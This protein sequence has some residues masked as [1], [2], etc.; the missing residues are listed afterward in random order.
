MRFILWG[1]LV[2]VSLP[3][4]GNSDVGTV[5]FI[6]AQIYTLWIIKCILLFSF[7]FFQGLLSDIVVAGSLRVNFM[8]HD[9]RWN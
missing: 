3:S 8:L 7:F 1:W 2:T 5:I 4:N 9:A 6:S